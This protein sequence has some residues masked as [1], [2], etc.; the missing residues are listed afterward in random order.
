VWIVKDLVASVE[1]R[2]G[3]KFGREK[4]DWKDLWFERCD[5]GC[6]L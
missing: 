6:F 2:V 5:A 3:R 4:P 1:C